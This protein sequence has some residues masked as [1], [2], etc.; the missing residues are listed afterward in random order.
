MIC[1]FVIVVC[2][3][4]YEVTTAQ[5]QIAS[6]KFARCVRKCFR[7]RELVVANNLI[8]MIK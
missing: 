4:G 2:V 3:I 6:M 1:F 5:G 8:T 7:L